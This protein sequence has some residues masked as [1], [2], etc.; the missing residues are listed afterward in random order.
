MAISGSGPAP[1]P[2]RPAAAVS[3]SAEIDTPPT[4]FVVETVSETKVWSAA[5]VVIDTR[6]TC[7]FRF[8]S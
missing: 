6:S 7:T 8:V 3:P 4:K 1:S 5:C 2:H